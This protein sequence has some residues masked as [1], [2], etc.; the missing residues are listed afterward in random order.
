MP[1]L[2]HAF[3]KAL[4]RPETHHRAHPQG[5]DQQNRRR[6]CQPGQPPAH[7]LPAVVGSVHE[8]EALGPFEHPV[9]KVLRR[10]SSGQ[11]PEQAARLAQSTQ[12]L[13][14]ARV[15]PKPLLNPAG[16]RLG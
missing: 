14:Q 15:V 1:L 10:L 4:H 11:P 5:G 9:G 2:G 16:F 8:L 12:F 7:A 13:R 3:L 6:R